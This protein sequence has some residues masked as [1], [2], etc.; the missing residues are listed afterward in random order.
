MSCLQCIQLSF[1]SLKLPTH[2][3]GFQNLRKLD[4]NLLHVTR[5]DLEN[6]L[7]NCGSLEWLSIARCHLN[8]ELR[9]E[10]PLSHLVYLRVVNCMIT[11]VQFHATRLSTFEYK[12]DFVPL[13]FPR[14]LKME[15]ANILFF[16]VAFQHA[17]SALLNAIPSI[18]NLTF[19]ILFLRIEAQWDLGYQHMLSQLRNVQLLVHIFEEDL[20][21]VLY[22]VSFLKAAPL[23]EKLE[24][25]FGGC[26]ELW[27][28]NKGPARHHL[29][30][31]PR[32]EYKYLKDIHITG[33]K[34]AR[35]QLQFLL[36]IIEQAPA[37]ETLTVHTT[38]LLPEACFPEEI[39]PTFFHD[40]GRHARDHLRKELSPRVRLC[41]V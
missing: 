16:K 27:F 22:L 25:H 1:V 7:S 32:H 37:L 9:V 2:F 4:L 10:S 36:H 26:G 31:H 28:S 30:P 39:G 17:L 3:R 6:M 11:K 15:N 21:N 24:V 35:G 40:A 8:D 41:V 29:P 38:Q 23:I 33:Y 13:I 20:D 12:G 19:Q 18:Q 14:C 34:A 5:K